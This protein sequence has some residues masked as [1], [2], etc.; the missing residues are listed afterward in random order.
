MLK[1]ALIGNLGSDAR[2]EEH[3]GH[4]FVSFN[5]AHNDRYQGADGTMTESITWVSCALNGDGGKLLPYLVKGRQVYVEGKGSTRVYSSPTLRR[6]V[7]GLNI[8]VDRI[9]LIGG[10]VDAVPRSLVDNEGTIHTVHKAYYLEQN[11]AKELGA[12]KN[13]PV[14]IS[15]VDGRLFNVDGLGWV[16][17]VSPEP[18]GDTQKEEQTS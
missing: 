9:E 4:K 11:E 7:A 17:P 6:I 12:K 10:Q 18:T 3:N 8:A 2:V 15:S 14:T 16:T 5:V 13:A 1:F